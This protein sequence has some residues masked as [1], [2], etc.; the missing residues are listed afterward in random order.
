MRRALIVAFTLAVLP[1]AAFDLGK[2]AEELADKQMESWKKEKIETIANDPDPK[3]RLEAVN[4]LPSADPDAC[5]AFAAALSDRDAAVRRAA[6]DQLW[7]CDKLAA[8]YRSQL[9]KAL[10][11]PD[12]N[13]VAYVAGALQS[14][15]VREA[16]L[17]PARKRVLAAPEASVSARFLVAR[18]LVG[19][20][21]PMKLVAPMIAYLERNTRN[22]TGSVTD[23]NGHNVELA[24]KALA[25]LVKNTKDR[26]L[27]GPLMQAL[28]ETSNGQIPL[29]KTLGHFEPRPEG[30]TRTL[31]DHLDHPNPRV[32][33][34]ALT[35]L[36]SVKQE[37]EVARWAPRAAQMLQDPDASVRS[38]AL[39][40]LGSA[41]GLAAGQIDAVVAAA[42]DADPSVRRSA[43]R[44]LGEMAEGN[45]AVPAA[46]RARLSAAARPAL[47]K[48]MQDEDKDV[49]DEAKDAL[50]NVERSGGGA[51]LASAAPSASA[52][53][54]PAAASSGSEAAGLAYLRSKKVKFDE[55]SWFQ[56][57]SKLDVD[58]VRAFL[59]AGVSPN[60]SVTDL[61]PPMRTMLF[62]S[63]AC[64]PAER[65]TKPQPKA[66]VKLLLERGAD[67][68]GSDKNGNT[69][70]SE[71][72]SR[73][74]DRELIRTLIKA[75]G[76]MNATNVSGLTPFEMGLWSGHDGL[77][78][79]V[80]A[81]YRLPP[82]KVKM[83]LDGYKD[84]PAAIMMVKK[85]APRK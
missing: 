10:D 81:G 32:R 30:W 43:V 34:E 50:R 68:K 22:Y 51:R 19:Y 84:R 15:G 49:R 64:S 72:A 40:A 71:A 6:A 58:L 3:A 59:D 44:A 55:H 9:T 37:K 5:M 38:E 26:T 56:A 17:A 28:Q 70:L 8:P 33:Y 78:E 45:Q 11:D 83:Y 48:A 47:D 41:A 1:A 80:A 67:V 21:S 65:P 29:L 54:S 4:G 75:G 2:W 53:A 27:V 42:S 12:A 76:N 16:E 69:A 77:E 82:Q 63:D 62:S 35:Q 66:I 24:E 36:R 60:A 73:G 18:N 13:V 7:N 79:F 52:A 31:M 46:T 25:R 20:E 14:I 57:L 61:G 23:K 85:A 74:C 39:W